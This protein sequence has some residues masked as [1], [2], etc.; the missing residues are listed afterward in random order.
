MSCGQLLDQERME[1]YEKIKENSIIKKC[2]SCAKTNT[3][4]VLQRSIIRQVFVSFKV[5]I[6]LQKRQYTARSHGSRTANL[7]TI[8]FRNDRLYI[9]LKA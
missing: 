2:K 7:L 6:E 1:Y 3:P 4:Q 9:A 8:M 5:A